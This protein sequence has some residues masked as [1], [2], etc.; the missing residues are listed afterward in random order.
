MKQVI[1]KYFKLSLNFGISILRLIG[2]CLKFDYVLKWLFQPPHQDTRSLELILIPYIPKDFSQRVVS[3]SLLQNTGLLRDGET[4]NT[5]SFTDILLL[6]TDLVEQET[7]PKNMRNLF[8]SNYLYQPYNYFKKFKYPSNVQANSFLSKNA[9][10]YIVYF[11]FLK[12]QTIFAEN[13]LRRHSIF[14]IFNCYYNVGLSSNT[15]VTEN[16]QLREIYSF[17]IFFLEYWYN[18]FFLLNKKNKMFIQNPVQFIDDTRNVYTYIN[19]VYALNLN[20]IEKYFLS[21][22]NL[23]EFSSK[24]ILNLSEINF[25]N[26]KY[27]NLFFDVLLFQYRSSFVMYENSFFEIS[28]LRYNNNFFFLLF[29][30]INKKNYFML[31]VSFLFFGLIV[32]FLFWGLDKVFILWFIFCGYQLFSDQYFLFQFFFGKN[33]RFTAISL[34]KFLFLNYKCAQIDDIK[35]FSTEYKLYLKKLTNVKNNLTIPISENFITEN[36]LTR[37][38]YLDFEKGFFDKYITELIYYSFLD[39]M[40]NHHFLLHYHKYPSR[41]KNNFFI[42]SFPLTHDEFH[43]EQFLFIK[44]NL[45]LEKNYFNSLNFFFLNN[46]IPLI[47]FFFLSENTFFLSSLLS[48]RN[49]FDTFQNKKNIYFFCFQLVNK[50]LK[51]L[52]NSLILTNYFFKENI[53]FVFFIYNLFLKT[54]SVNWNILCDDYK[55]LFYFFKLNYLAMESTYFDVIVSTKNIDMLTTTIYDLCLRTFESDYLLEDSLDSTKFN[56]LFKQQSGFGFLEL[57]NFEH[58]GYSIVDINDYGKRDIYG[59]LE[60]YTFWPVSIELESE[61]EN[62]QK[63][64]SESSVLGLRPNNKIHS[65]LEINKIDNETIV[66]GSIYF[67]FFDLYE[68]NAYVRKNLVKYFSLVQDLFVFNEILIRSDFNKINWV[69]FMSP[70]TEF[71]FLEKNFLANSALNITTMIINN[72]KSLKQFLQELYGSVI[73]EEYKVILLEREIWSETDL[74]VITNLSINDFIMEHNFLKSEFNEFVFLEIFNKKPKAPFLIDNNIIYDEFDIDRFYDEIFMCINKNSDLTEEHLLLYTNYVFLDHENELPRFTEISLLID[75]F[76]DYFVDI[77]LFEDIHF[78][79]FSDIDDQFTE[80]EEEDYEELKIVNI[81]EGAELFESRIKRFPF[82]LGDRY[83]ELSAPFDLVYEQKNVFESRNLSESEFVKMGDKLD[84]NNDF[85]ELNH[86]EYFKDFRNDHLEEYFD[87][88]EKELNPEWRF[89]TQEEIIEAEEFDE[90]YDFEEDTYLGDDSFEDYEW[91]FWENI[92]EFRDEQYEFL[93]NIDPIF[94]S[95]QFKVFQNRDFYLKKNQITTLQEDF[96]FYYN[97]CDRLKIQICSILLA[98]MFEEK[99]FFF[100][101]YSRYLKKKKTLNFI[102]YEIKNKK[103]PKWILNHNFFFE[104]LLSRYTKILYNLNIFYDIQKNQVSSSFV[105]FNSLLTDLK[106]STLHLEISN[107]TDPRNMLLK[108]KINLSAV[109]KEINFDTFL[110]EQTVLKALINSLNKNIFDIDVPFL[111]KVEKDKYINV[112]QYLFYTSQF[113]FSKNFFETLKF[114]Y[115]LQILQKNFKDLSF[116]INY[117]FEFFC[118]RFFELTCKLSLFEVNKQQIFYFDIIQYYFKRYNLNFLQIPFNSNDV[119]NLYLLL[120]QTDIYVDKNLFLKNIFTNELGADF[121][122][123]LVDIPTYINDF[124]RRMLVQNYNSYD[125]EFFYTTQ[126]HEHLFFEKKV[127]QYFSYLSLRKFPPYT[128]DFILL[129]PQS[130]QILQLPTI[131]GNNYYLADYFVNFYF[132]EIEF[133]FEGEGFFV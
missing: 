98:E 15:F 33:S 69:Q 56:K 26:K 28:K 9:S 121:D 57:Q 51:N 86:F 110:H 48:Y 58:F 123:T 13:L 50:F 77:Q 19:L 108:S 49:F 80:E 130:F 72:D 119:K 71:C 133:D 93:F 17:D 11:N 91:I 102:F 131:Q 127:Y 21:L 4:K 103:C 42:D 94:F 46:Q 23:N 100:K 83:D 44:R 5:N 126:M 78:N 92:M 32:L 40:M 36:F 99:A 101:K 60:N 7:S 89:L 34:Q 122:E 39:M 76:F 105:I 106:K 10:Y 128:N 63:V 52:T 1:Q 45:L 22:Q 59:F 88:F 85:L 97:T 118:F 87:E 6:V 73:L 114:P 95:S 104:E 3:T 82:S 132:C 61:N 2:I 124:F 8:T 117:D 75:Y 107:Y 113:F 12:T 62:Q 125:K 112:Q 81:L 18:V 53:H 70:S 43:K 38:T 24:I 16:Y 65:S 66:N 84:I 31:K 30:K 111:N 109:Q 64:H 37:S 54:K 41:I 120:K 47:L 25:F 67:Y 27:F 55:R 68:N 90:N 29:Q 115:N 14:E 96:T 79:S 74:N 129:K 20:N 116:I 35:F